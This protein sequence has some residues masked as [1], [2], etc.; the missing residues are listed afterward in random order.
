MWNKLRGRLVL[1]RQRALKAFQ[2]LPYFLKQRRAL[3][4]ATVTLVV[5]SAVEVIFPLVA[6]QL[7][8]DIS[9]GQRDLL[10]WTVLGLLGIYV[11]GTVSQFTSQLLI[12]AV[13]ERSTMNLRTDVYR[14]LHRLPA[15]F[16]VE[17][18][19]GEV[20]SRL[21]NDI[22]Q[23]RSNLSSVFTGLVTDTLTIVGILVVLAA[24]QWQMALVLPLL[25]VP[26]VIMTAALGII[27]NHIAAIIQR[28]LAAAFSLAEDALQ[29]HT[30]VRAYNREPFE[31]NRFRS[32]LEDSFRNA[33]R[34]VYWQ[35][36][37]GAF[38]GLAG[39]LA[40]TGVLVLVAQAVLDESFDLQE[41]VTFLYYAALLWSALYGWMWVYLGIQMTGGATERVF[42]I[43]GLEP[44]I[45]DAPNA[46]D[47]PPGP[48]HVRLENVQFAYDERQPV[49]REFSLEIAPGET[50]ALV[51]PSGT[52]KTTV[53]KLIFRF[54]DPQVGRVLIDGT[55]VK[56]ITQASLRARLG[57]VF[58]DPF[59]FATT[60]YENIRYGRPDAD[61]A[62]VIEAAQLANAHDF[63]IDMPDG[64][65]TLVGERGLR[66]SRGQRQ[67][68][69]LA[70]MIL[71]DPQI[72]ILDEVTASLD[73]ATEAL[74]IDT[75]QEHFP[76]RTTLLITHHPSI[77]QIANRIVVLDQGRVSEEGTH[78]QL[79][80]KPEGVYAR[81]FRLAQVMEDL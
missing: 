33:M 47:L 24:L 67:R 41:V 65:Q 52:G 15:Q 14:H 70:R 49:L 38:M 20:L 3:S 17:N 28:H 39:R 45:V 73:K 44:S 22:S 79:L 66:L 9:T 48:G 60:V 72:L 58:Q 46:P 25:L 61:E 40:A 31:I 16:F 36:G 18:Q 4:W 56:T 12:A 29:G 7:F 81:L 59:V 64:Y 63:I 62:A 76:N 43:L 21:T 57:T 51:G 71:A 10:S 6:V 80:A 37:V 13:G 54:Y 50:V 11:I 78:E 19:S 5:A 2:I 27:L 68:I 55:D 26:L 8:A 75:L 1:Q 74:V 77:A 69:A 34:M 42:H 23:L 35:S 53:A 32:A 30:T